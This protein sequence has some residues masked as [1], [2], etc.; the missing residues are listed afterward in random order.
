MWEKTR[1]FSAKVRGLIPRIATPL[2]PGRHI[3]SRKIRRLVRAVPFP[4]VIRWR[5]EPRRDE[6]RDRR[7]ALWSITTSAV[8][9]PCPIRARLSKIKYKMTRQRLARLSVKSISGIPNLSALVPSSLFPRLD[10]A[11]LV[12]R[13]FP[14]Y[15]HIE[16][17]KQFYA[18][19]LP[20]SS[21][22]S[23]VSDISENN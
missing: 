4:V 7:R 12:A 2:S 3:L 14:L 11:H 15:S 5:Q 13:F 6:T 10:T 1:A 22:S 9:A 8:N 23:I 20:F 21:K 19:S 16:S 18:F 17:A